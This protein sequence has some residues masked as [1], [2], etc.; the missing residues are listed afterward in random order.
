MPN[1]VQAHEDLLRVILVEEVSY[2]R[3]LWHPFAH[4]EACQE[5][6]GALRSQPRAPLMDSAACR[7]LPSA[8]AGKVILHLLPL[9]VCLLTPL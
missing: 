9:H 3:V 5:L 7:L 1:L 6:L 8:P 4:V 2:L